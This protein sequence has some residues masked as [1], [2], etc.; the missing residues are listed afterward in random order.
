MIF[1]TAEAPIYYKKEIDGIVE[2]PPHTTVLCLHCNSLTTT[3]KAS[4][5]F[6]E[7]IL[8]NYSYG[9]PNC[10]KK[11]EKVLV[12]EFKYVSERVI[13]I[14]SDLDETNQIN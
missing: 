4:E 12:T 3:K 9:C 8:T 5:V 7:E 13:V 11:L 10:K 1:N 6:K 14:G 2:P